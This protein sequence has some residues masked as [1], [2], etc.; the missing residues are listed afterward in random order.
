MKKTLALLL[1]IL[2]VLALFGCTGTTNDESTEAPTTDASTAPSDSA[3]VSK[4]TIVYLCNMIFPFCQ[5]QSATYEEII[6]QDNYDVIIADINNSAETEI[7]LMETYCSEGVAGFIC[8]S[9]GTISNRI[10]EIV[11]E[12]GIPLVSDSTNLVDSATGKLLAPG[13]ELNAYDCGSL[14]SQWIVENYEA[15]GFADV[16]VSTL[17]FIVATYNAIPSFID[18]AQGAIDSF[19][20]GFPDCENIF[21][22]DTVN[23]GELTAEAAYTETAAILSAHPDITTWFIVGI[24]DDL[25]QG[26]ARAVEEAS[27]EDN[28]IITSVGGEVLVQEW[29]SGYE[30]CWKACAFFSG[31]DFANAL[32]P[33]LKSVLDD[34]VAL[35]DLFPDWKQDGETFAVYKVTGK[36]TTRE[37]YLDSIG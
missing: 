36:N 14:C 19:S 9:D 21:A 11:T 7:Q 25:A 23:Q 29:E 30:G 26:A 20:A 16:D 35:E 13:C 5:V 32:W 18:R 34:G 1:A 8:M 28:V 37:M 4:G 17:G 2:M 24:L 15:E 12:A 27:I 33:A 22:A 6:P 3:A 31:A 10:L